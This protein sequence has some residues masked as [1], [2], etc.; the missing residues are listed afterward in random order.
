[1]LA[2]SLER[3]AVKETL[4]EGGLL[5]AMSDNPQSLHGGNEGGDDRRRYNREM[6]RRPRYDY[7]R[8]SLSNTRWERV[9]RLIPTC[10]QW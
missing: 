10:V 7:L 9:N 4:R 1:M 5:V 8:L 2:C 6:P 3:Y